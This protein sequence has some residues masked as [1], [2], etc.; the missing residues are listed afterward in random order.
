M[1]NPC[2]LI[3]NTAYI[4]E[5]DVY[6]KGLAPGGKFVHAGNQRLDQPFIFDHLDLICNQKQL[7]GSQV[8]SKSETDDM[9]KF[10]VLHSI[11][12]IVEKYPWKD[13]QKAFDRVNSA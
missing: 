12:P 1:I 7:L 13:M 10:S 4:N 3:L 11:L 2:D 9:L 5:L 8:G 6:V